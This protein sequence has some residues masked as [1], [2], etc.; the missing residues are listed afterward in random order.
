MYQGA[1]GFGEDLLGVVECPKVWW[2]V[3]WH[4]LGCSGVARCSAVWTG[5][6]GNRL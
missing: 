3:W 5:L 1:M 6:A 4:V 2:G